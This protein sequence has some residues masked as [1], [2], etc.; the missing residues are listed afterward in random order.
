[1][2]RESKLA[3]VISITLVLLVG[4]LI[5]DHMSSATVA[6]FETPP[7]SERVVNRPLTAGIDGI[8]R[9]PRAPQP[10]AAEQSY[11]QQ[12]AQPIYEQPV[13]PQDEYAYIDETQ[14]S[15]EAPVVIAQGG[16]SEPPSI[17]GTAIDRFRETE[18]PALIGTGLF[19]RVDDQTVTLP[20]RDERKLD[21]PVK[22]VSEPAEARPSTQATAQG[23]QRWVTHTVSEG[24]SLYA[25]ARDLL[26]D[27][28]RWPELQKLNSDQL[29][30]GEDIRVGMVLKIKADTGRSQA[31]R[32]PQGGTQP[33]AGV[34]EYVV[35]KGD[36]LGK[37]ASQLLGSSKRMNEIV[38]LN[39]LKDP[40]DIRVG[41]TLKIPSR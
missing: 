16:S 30:G 40:N 9:L 19:Q 8:D 23:T 27:G 38:E 6:E 24:E 39:G 36:I 17:L 25:I 13:Y 41:Q 20:P 14:P 33:A 5:S 29:Q 18:A 12:G 15:D 31:V 7:A 37:I 35:Q 10:R 1:M 3:L 34:R 22:P 26:G 2:T 11:A 21:A 28:S 32:A 4:V